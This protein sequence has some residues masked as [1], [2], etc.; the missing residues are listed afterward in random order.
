M[1]DLSPLFGREN[2]PGAEHLAFR[3]F[4]KTGT[5]R[6]MLDATERFP[7]H[8][9]TWPRAN[10]RARWIYRAAWALGF[11]GLHLPSRV[12]SF[13][14]AANSPYAQLRTEFDRLGI[15]L[16][17]PGPNRKIV[18]YAGR[19]ERSVFVKIPL[20]PASS[21]LVVQ[22]AAA[23][24]DLAQ[25]PDLAPLV[26]R[27]YR[28]AGHLA[29][30]N[31]DTHDTRHAALDL[32]ELVRIHDLLERRS[33]TVRPLS[34]LRRDWEAETGASEAPMKCNAQIT[35]AIEGTRE[36][37]YAFLD[38]LPQ[39]LAVPCYMAHG[40]FTRWNVLRAADGSAR[41]IDWELYGLRPR[42]FDLV[43]YFVSYDLLVAR[44][45]AAGVVM[46]LGRVAKEIGVE[47]PEHG[48]WRQVGLYLA[49]HGL[50]YCSVYERQE[51][52]YPQA[53]WQLSAWADILRMLSMSDR[54]EN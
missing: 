5:E 27:A 28:I 13:P 12:L 51:D 36:A 29:L 35:A 22:E 44:I 40:D 19:P 24:D 4:P 6:W 3:V 34:E 46:H 47:T 18:V 17:T 8:L 50:Y 15:F 43:H 53:V 20:G 10:M 16:G 37:A 9:K 32:T 49:C 23:L 45:P 39:D 21:A 38:S 2:T 33:V 11:L 31:I 41:I 25:D 30:E 7:W 42:W 26:P 52:P 48:W 54:I 14:I 1:I